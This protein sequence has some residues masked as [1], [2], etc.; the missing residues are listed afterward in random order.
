VKSVFGGAATMLGYYRGGSNVKNIANAYPSVAQSGTL[1]LLSFAG[2]IN[3]TTF[4]T[5]NTDASD[6]Q[7]DGSGADAG[8]YAGNEYGSNILHTPN[9]G[10][11]T[12]LLAGNRGDYEIQLT[13]TSGTTPTG[14]A[15]NTWFNMGSTGITWYLSQTPNNGS[16][17]FYGQLKIRMSASPQTILNTAGVY[18]YVFAASNQCPQC[19]FTPDTLISMGDGTTRAIAMVMVGDEILVRGGTKRVTEVITRTNRVMYQIQFADGRVLNASEDHPLYV[20]DKGYAA[21]NPGVGGDYK[22]LG[23]PD[24]LYVGDLVLDSEGRENQIVD[25]IDL[26]YPETVYTFAES[27]FYANGMLVY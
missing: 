7:N 24:Q 23:I 3:P 8:I 19:C 4:L 12:W 15:V 13:K 18:L 26:D 10:N 6:S 20:V 16:K 21:I 14:S 11:P 22:D 25:I 9:G 5:A 17:T 1:S 2:V 27:E